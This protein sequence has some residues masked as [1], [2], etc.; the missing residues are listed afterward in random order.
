VSASR[1]PDDF[2]SSRRPRSDR[3]DSARTPI[4]GA[5]R[6]AEAALL[7]LLSL[8]G[9]PACAHEDWRTLPLYEDVYRA[10]KPK[11]TPD[12]QPAADDKPKPEVKLPFDELIEDDMPADLTRPALELPKAESTDWTAFKDGS[13]TRSVGKASGGRLPNGRRLPAEGRGL[14][15][16]NDKAPYGTDETVALLLWAGDQMVT[17]Y[18]GTVPMVVGDLSREGGGRLKPHASHQTGRDADLGYFQ[19]ENRYYRQFSETTLDSIDVE[20]TWTLLEL[21]LSSRQ[22][23]YMFIDRRLHKA[24]Y[25]EASRRG[26]PEAELKQLFE[27]PVGNSPRTGLIRHQKG[28]LNHFHVRFRCDPSDEQCQ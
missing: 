14:V 5:S 18:P 13:D 21:L 1:Q 22:V 12:D 4:P 10:E 6:A 8:A 28:H 2:G 20:K 11:E 16:K 23:D 24:L 3:V 7:F 27:A 17:L 19:K 25:E 26:W 15:R 9:Q